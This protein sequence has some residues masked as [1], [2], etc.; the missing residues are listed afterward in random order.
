MRRSMTLPR[1]VLP[2]PDSPTRPRVS[3]RRTSKRHAVHGPDR[4]DLA[5]AEQPA[6]D[7]EVLDDV[8]G[9][10]RAR[11]PGSVWPLVRAVSL[12]ASRVAPSAGGPSGGG[13]SGVGPVT[14]PKVLDASTESC[15]AA[16]SATSGGAAAPTAGGSPFGGQPAAREMAFG[17]IF[18]S[19]G[20]VSQIGIAYGQRRLNRQPFGRLSGLGTVPWMTSRRSRFVAE[21]RDRGEQALA[22]TGDGARRRSS[23]PSAL[24][25]DLAGVHDDD[26]VGH[27]GDD[28]EVV[29]DEHDRHLVARRACAFMSSRICAWIVTS[30]AVVGS[31]AMSSAGFVERAMAIITRWR[32]PPDSWWGYSFARRLA[33]GMPTR[34]EHLDG[35]VHRLACA[36]D[37]EVERDRLGDLVAAGEDRVERGHRLLEDHR[38]RVAADVPHVVLGELQRGRGRRAGSRPPRSCPAGR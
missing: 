35:P 33:S 9:P 4:A 1:V 34:L 11:P 38:D 18:W 24:L 2:Q 7:L 19:G 32:M 30:S 14:S 10:G 3:P 6:P 25:D 16:S 26:V 8:L 37:L 5:D 13:A 12:N 29:G 31:S 22:C 27:L 15:A 17:T 28:A 20:A 21:P 36:I 23:S